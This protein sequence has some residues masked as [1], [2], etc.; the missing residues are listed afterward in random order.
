MCFLK[1]NVPMLACSDLRTWSKLAVVFGGQKDQNMKDLK[2]KK[3]IFLHMNVLAR[4][5]Q[6]KYIFLIGQFLS[7]SV[8]LAKK[9]L[10]NIHSSTNVQRR[11]WL[12]KW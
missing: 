8:V 3:I 1:C 9:C 7:L 6:S 2:N 12:Q 11:C 10:P 4:I 5:A